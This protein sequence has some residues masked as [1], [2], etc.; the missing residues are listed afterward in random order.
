MYKLGGE[1][2]ETVEDSREDARV[3][4]CAHCTYARVQTNARGSRFQR[5]LRSDDDPAYT[6]YPPLPVR[7]CAGYVRASEPEQPSE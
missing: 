7:E 3:G 5:C 6:K 4:L 1:G 2:S